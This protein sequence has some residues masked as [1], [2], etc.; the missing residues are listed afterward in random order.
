MKQTKLLLP[1]ILLGY[2]L[3]YITLLGARPLM[4]PDETRYA[5]VAREMLV[6]GDF[7]V[8]HLNGLSSW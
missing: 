4:I 2:L 7:I 3:V 5:E 1:L 8:P 6:S